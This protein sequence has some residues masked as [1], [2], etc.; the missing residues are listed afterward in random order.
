MVQNRE[1]ETNGKK[2]REKEGKSCKLKINFIFVEGIWMEM[3]IAE[4]FAE[5]WKD[6]GEEIAR[7]IRI[8]WMELQWIKNWNKISE[9]LNF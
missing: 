8:K 7:K 6:F 4:E 5:N 2:M 1:M 9:I 3:K